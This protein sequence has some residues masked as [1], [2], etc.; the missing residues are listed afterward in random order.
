MEVMIVYTI[1]MCK[2]GDRMVVLENSKVVFFVGALQLR[3]CWFLSSGMRKDHS[4]LALVI[5]VAIT[6][7]VLLRKVQY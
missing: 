7:L 6:V 4:Y 1:Y 2:Q 3:T 5:I